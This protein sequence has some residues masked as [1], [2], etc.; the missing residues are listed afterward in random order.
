MSPFWILLIAALPVMA[1][2]YFALAVTVG[3]WVLDYEHRVEYND[4]LYVP[5][6]GALAIAASYAFPLELSFAF[7]TYYL[8]FLALGVGMYWLDMA[9]LARLTGHIR[10][11]RQHLY[12]TVPVLAI[13]VV[14][15]VLFRGILTVVIAEYGTVAYVASS[16]LLFGIN[17]YRKGRREVA[18]KTV[19]GVVY[20]LLYVATGSLLS[21]ILAHLGYNVAYVYRATDAIG[22]E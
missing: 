20:C 9:V 4:W 10:S 13:A 14:E 7:R 1:A 21:P 8:L 6:V 2:A 15:E 22:N 5:F 18:F 17:H 12:W 3:G 11:G 16:S 19:N